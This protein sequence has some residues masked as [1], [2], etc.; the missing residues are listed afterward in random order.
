MR[1]LLGSQAEDLLAA[2]DEPPT[3][4][5]RLNTLRLGEGPEGAGAYTRVLTSLPWAR[6]SVPWCESGFALDVAESDVKPGLHPWHAAGVYYLQDP[7]AMAVAEAL[8]PAAGERVLDLAAAPGGKSTHLA[9]LLGGRGVIVCN[10]PHPARARAL[11]SNI[12]RCGVA[13]AVVVSNSV[14]KLARCFGAWFDRVLLDAPCSGEGMFRKSEAA[15]SAWGPQTVSA[16]AARQSDLLDSAA[17]LVRPGGRLAYSTCTF[18]R[19]ENEDVVAGFLARRPGFELETID[20]PGVDPGL[21]EHVGA[22]RVWP[23][24]SVG[25]GHFVALLRRAA[26]ETPPR[27]AARTGRGR[28]A[29]ARLRPDQEQ[30]R[31]WREHAGAVSHAAGTTGEEERIVAHGDRL[32]LAPSEWPDLSGVHVLR[33]GLALGEVKRHSRRPRFEPAHAAAM[34][35]G[36]PV[37][38]P[39][40]QACD[41]GLDD[42]RLARYLA[43]LDMPAD[44]A[45][46]W[47]V[48]RAEGY[49]LGWGRLRA[50]TLRSALP[51]GLRRSGT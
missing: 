11:L 6:R 50:G 37:G 33:V 39:V 2:L 4:G 9:A 18:S 34:V 31:A 1:E 49:P 10:D 36:Q 26:D 43:G 24:R 40:P 28:A 29:A 5:L 13:N 19:A 14:D 16:C 51:S 27:A 38:V 42:P 46:G 20:L 22:A 41:L 12:E 17:A 32:M 15:R 47:T 48:V 23:H 35:A 8:A 25:D 21:G 45:D 7:S 44:G 30:L 3:V